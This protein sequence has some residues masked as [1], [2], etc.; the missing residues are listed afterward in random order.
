MGLEEGCPRETEGRRQGQESGRAK[1]RRGW[2]R[3][4][5]EAQ[6]LGDLGERKGGHRQGDPRVQP[7]AGSGAT[8]HQGRGLAGEA[9]PRADLLARCPAPGRKGWAR[10]SQR[11]SVWLGV[12]WGGCAVLLEGGPDDSRGVGRGLLPL[13]ASVALR[14]TP[15]GE[16]G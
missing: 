3:S 11:S 13:G 15:S 9:G 16:G 1:G 14:G 7:R 8:W 12:G 6:S 10:A 4:R 2:G 5:Q